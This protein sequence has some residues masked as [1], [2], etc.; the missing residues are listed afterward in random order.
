MQLLRKLQT[1]V[2]E[3]IQ[4]AIPVRWRRVA[5]FQYAMNTTRSSYFGIRA[6]NIEMMLLDAPNRLG[7][8]DRMVS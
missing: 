2:Y 6:S 8:N 7:N 4:E 5:D 3:E 1:L